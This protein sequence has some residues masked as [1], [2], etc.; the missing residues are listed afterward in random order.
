MTQHGAIEFCERLFTVPSI[1][2]SSS[3]PDS[4]PCAFWNRNENVW[5]DDNGIMLNDLKDM[6]F[7]A[8][9]RETILMYIRQHEEDKYVALVNDFGDPVELFWKRRIKN[10]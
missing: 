9:M 4:G 7:S 8:R 6:G 10:E 1:F 2:D 5:I 3:P